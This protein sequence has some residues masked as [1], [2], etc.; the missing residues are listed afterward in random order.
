MMT[1]RFHCLGMEVFR[2]LVLGLRIIA[3]IFQ[4][5]AVLEHDTPLRQRDYDTIVYWQGT[6]S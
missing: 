4:F 1:I 5:D 2:F 6:Y 3:V